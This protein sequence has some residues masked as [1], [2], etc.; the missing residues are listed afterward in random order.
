VFEWCS[1]VDKQDHADLA[2]VLDQSIS[3]A[4][5]ALWEHRNDESKGLSIASSQQ[6]P[7]IWDRS[8]RTQSTRDNASERSSEHATA[9][10]REYHGRMISQ[11][12]LNIADPST[13]KR[14]WNEH[15]KTMPLHDEYQQHIHLPAC[16]EIFYEK[17][18]DDGA[19]SS[20]GRP[21]T[22]QTPDGICVLYLGPNKRRGFEEDQRDTDR[23]K[24]SLLT[25]KSHSSVE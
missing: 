5:K 1:T 2:N 8:I 18:T 3:N 23:S 9:D 15:V 13:S 10:N 16:H 7:Y 12:V 6:S 14:S 25:L 22:L 19:P 4:S 24:C 20:I 11:S 21:G 17:Q